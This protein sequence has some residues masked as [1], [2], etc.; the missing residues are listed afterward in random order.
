[1]T[2]GF[3]AYNTSGYLLIDNTYQNLSLQIKQT[4]SLS[5]GASTTVTLTNAFSPMLFIN[6][7]GYVGLTNFYISGTTAIWTLQAASTST[8]AFYVFDQPLANATTGYGMIVRN[9]AGTQVFN[10]T[11]KYLRVVDVLSVPYSNSNTGVSGPNVTGTY[12]SA[13]YACCLSMP[14]LEEY[15]SGGGNVV[16]TDAINTTSTSVTIS[17]NLSTFY[18]SGTV[19]SSLTGVYFGT[20]TQPA[21]VCNV[22]GY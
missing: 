1:M 12:P 13:T 5:A 7:S 9:A 2:Y 17:H 18:G 21:M 3:E 16:A 22:S 4:Y 19:V 8:G 20:G 15:A 11:N 6:A 10:S 14:R